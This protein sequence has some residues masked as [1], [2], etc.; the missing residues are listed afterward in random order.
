MNAS[1]PAEQK[2]AAGR[3]TDFT[4]EI[5]DAIC[6]RLADGESLRSICRDQH[7]PTKGCVFRWLSDNKDFADQYTRAREAQADS[8]IDDIVD[9]ADDKGLDPNDKR[10]RIDARKWSAGKMRPKKYGDKVAVVGGGA[11]D[12]PIQTLDLTKATD[13]QLAK[14]ES[15]LGA[16]ANPGAGEGGT[17]TQGG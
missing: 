6:E 16:I 2:A 3:P 9:I 7:M 10:I 17:E 13:E 12:A 4:Q 11:G 15:I 14:L 8:H 5:A 1:L